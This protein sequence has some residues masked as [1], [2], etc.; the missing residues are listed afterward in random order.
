[1]RYTFPATRS[2]LTGAAGRTLTVYTDEKTTSLADIQTT[3]GVTI[4]GSTLT[5]D[6]ESDIPDFL[7]PDNVKT[8]YGKIDKLTIPIQAYIA[9]AT[10]TSGP[11]Y[12]P[13]VWAAGVPYGVNYTTTY[14]GSSYVSLSD[15]NIGHV[16]D[17]SPTYW[18]PF[19]VGQAGSTRLQTARLTTNQTV[20]STTFVDVAGLTVAPNTVVPIVLVMTG[21]VRLSQDTGTPT[22]QVT[23]TF[24][25]VDDLGTVVGARPISTVPPVGGDTRSYH[26][27]FDVT[28]A[29]AARTY[30]VQVKS[31]ATTSSVVLHGAA[32]TVGTNGGFAL[33]AQI[34]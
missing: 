34:Q 20:T 2:V 25:V 26:I 33:Q 30:K 7:G 21:S 23:G 6:A 19:A 10:P 12:A 28:P 9:P 4:S 3:G 14:G 16:P 27:E 32:A 29:S 24:Q 1:M 22:A 17:S 18:Q 8:L 11:L 15:G 13:T 5:L 31:S